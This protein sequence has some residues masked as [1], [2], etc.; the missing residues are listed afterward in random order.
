[1]LTLT[2][3]AAPRNQED[4]TVRSIEEDT[5]LVEYESGYIMGGSLEM[6][7]SRTLERSPGTAMPSVL[8]SMGEEQNVTVTALPKH[9]VTDPARTSNSSLVERG[10]KRKHQGL[11][12]PRKKV[13]KSRPQDS[14]N[15]EGEIRNQNLMAP[16]PARRAA[17]RSQE[18]TKDL[19]SFCGQSNRAVSE[20]IRD[21]TAAPIIFCN[22]NQSNCRICS[23][24]NSRS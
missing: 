8:N 22:C 3:R 24:R 2:N 16:P 12:T 4:I 19:I 13:Q 23:S 11:E 14:N 6:E 21:R 7:P 15:T 5:D 20:Q 17:I 10:V 1:M 18:K 9:P